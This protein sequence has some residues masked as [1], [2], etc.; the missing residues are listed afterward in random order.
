MVS[1]TELM[2]SSIARL[3]SALTIEEFGRLCE[4][5]DLR[6]T[7]V[8]ERD[9]IQ[10]ITIRHNVITGQ[11]SIETKKIGEQAIGILADVMVILWKDYFKSPIRPPLTSGH[12]RVMIDLDGDSLKIVYGLTDPNN[13]DVL[14]VADAPVAKMMLIS[15]L[16]GLCE[17]TGG[18]DFDP[19]QALTGIEI[20]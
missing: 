17:Q 15:A 4:K 16:F 7:E 10:T 9:V 8:T 19:M 2:T 5:H 3:P 13:P 14:P 11:I 12:A 18:K 6:P 1:K 20:A